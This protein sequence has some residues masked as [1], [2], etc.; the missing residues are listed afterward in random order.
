MASSIP[1][2]CKQELRARGDALRLRNP[3]LYDALFS[4]G[5]LWQSRK[6]VLTV[7]RAKF[8]KPTPEQTNKL[9]AIDDLARLD[10]L[11]VRVLKVTSWDALLRGR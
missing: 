5:A 8:G 2:A 9:D 6:I 7:G 1:A 11:T 3:Y 10:R 4:L